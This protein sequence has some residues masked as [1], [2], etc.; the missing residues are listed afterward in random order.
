MTGRNG[1]YML[2][3]A[4]MLPSWARSIKLAFIQSNT[5]IETKGEEH[6]I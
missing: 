5:D 3:S 6:V 4:E 1:L 2:H